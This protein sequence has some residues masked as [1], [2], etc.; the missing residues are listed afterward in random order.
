MTVQQLI[1]LLSQCPPDA[2][3]DLFHLRYC[4]G[5]DEERIE[6]A[7]ILIDGDLRQVV[8]TPASLEEYAR[9][10]FFLDSGKRNRLYS[11]QEL[12]EVSK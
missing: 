8:I 4:G 7:A 6:D 3:V 12:L 5:G 10:S 2:W 11:V 1:N 9:H